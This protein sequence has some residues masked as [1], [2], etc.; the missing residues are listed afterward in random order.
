MFQN[1]LSSIEDV[2]IF[3]S[4]SFLTFF[5]FFIVM[6]VIVIRTDKKKIKEMSELPLNEK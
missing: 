4:I 5:I 6:T 2:G 1:V 3:P